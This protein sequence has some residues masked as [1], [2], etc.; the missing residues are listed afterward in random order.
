MGGPLKLRSRSH[1]PLPNREPTQASEKSGLK[2]LGENPSSEKTGERG[3]LRPDPTPIRVSCWCYTAKK[4]VW[5]RGRIEGKR[6]AQLLRIVECE[7]VDCPLR[8]SAYC[9]IG[10]LREGRWR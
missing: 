4:Q 6:Q 5:V 3:L 2:G 10:K 1:E 8:H 7:E 9:L